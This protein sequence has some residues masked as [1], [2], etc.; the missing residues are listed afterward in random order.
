MPMAGVTVPVEQLL[1]HVATIEH[2]VADIE[3]LVLRL[4]EAVKQRRK[5]E[6]RRAM[7]LPLFPDA[8]SP[9]A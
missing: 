7:Q 4:T 2:R 5:A 8:A 1:A 6:R 9:A 3:A